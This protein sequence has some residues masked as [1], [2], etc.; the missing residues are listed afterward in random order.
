[1]IR[2]SGFRTSDHGIRF[3]WEI[4]HTTPFVAA[5]ETEGEDHVRVYACNDLEKDAEESIDRLD[6]AAVAPGWF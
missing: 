6:G 4:L 1:M 5:R 2:I 3:I